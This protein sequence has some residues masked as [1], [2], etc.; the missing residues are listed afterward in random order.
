MRRDND[1][2]AAKDSEAP[3]SAQGPHH[4]CTGPTW[5]GGKRHRPVTLPIRAAAL[6]S[7]T[8]GVGPH[9]NWQGTDSPPDEHGL[10]EL[11]AESGPWV[12]SPK[13]LESISPPN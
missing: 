2:I 13:G 7:A 4:P 11:T 9:A 6:S 1:R 3:D 10:I 8:T 5:E 12:G